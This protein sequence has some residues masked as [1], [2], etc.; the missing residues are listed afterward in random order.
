MRRKLILALG[1]LLAL[2]AHAH[3]GSPDTFVQATAGPYKFLI[4]AHPPAVYPGALELDLRFNPADRIT[5][6]TASLDGSPTTPV[7]IFDAGTAT[8]TLW[9]PTPA[10]HTI[11]ITVQGSTYDLALPAAAVT[12][13]DKSSD[14]SWKEV[15]TAL[16]IIATLGFVFATLERR[17]RK[18]GRPIRFWHV[19]VMISA[20][21]VIIILLGK[22][23]DHRNAP[24]PQT[25]L[26]ASLTNGTLDI[27]LTNPAENFANLIPDDG[28]L[29]HLFLIRQPQQDVF[30][31]LHPHQLSPGH[32]TVA[33]P[34]MPPGTYRMFT[35]FYLSP[36]GNLKDARAETDT[37]TLD[38][39]ANFHPS[40]SDPDNTIAVLPPANAG[41]PHSSA[42]SSPMS[43]VTT[44][45]DSTTR[46][47]HQL[48]GYTL[49]LVTPGI[50]HP[51]HANLFQV[52]L[53]DPTGHPP[54]DMALYL[55]MPAHAVVVRSDNAVFAHIHPG[56][57]LPCSAIGRAPQVWIPR[58]GSRRHKCQC[59]CP[60]HPTSPPSPMAFPQPDVIASS[61]R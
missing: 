37:I 26:T 42:A 34:A 60:P 35:D 51:L 40:I 47:A 50:I 8:A 41:V 54:A 11:H 7:K 21:V 10:A 27:T 53:L 32:F 48:D 12:V 28:K 25:T 33:L 61:F 57:T 6:A 18:Q 19:M 30:L 14:F 44:S 13:P 24:Q 46:T 36:T 39:P 5:T 45:A 56:G 1:L 31:H 9:L 4:A 55:N 38:L 20:T 29:M 58:P 22:Y 23:F 15:S 17:R 59:Q 2:P 43:G 3:I 16:I 52:M 49:T